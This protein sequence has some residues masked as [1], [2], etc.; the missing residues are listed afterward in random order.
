MQ[1]KPNFGNDKMSANLNMTSNYGVLSALLGEKTK[2]I[3]TQLKPIQSQF[4]PI[5]TQFNPI[6][7]NNQSALITNH[8]VGK[9]NFKRKASLYKQ[10]DLLQ[11]DS[12]FVIG[13]LK[14]LLANQTEILR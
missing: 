13:H 12:G 1:N 9:S 14:S 4:N 7:A 5:Q 6:K 8:L 3:Q 11:L 2:P 10:L